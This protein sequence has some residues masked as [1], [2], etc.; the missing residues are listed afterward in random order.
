MN[1]GPRQQVPWSNP[2]HVGGPASERAAEGL[3]L[4]HAL[5]ERMRTGWAM[6]SFVIELPQPA[7]LGVLALAGFDFL[8]L[9]MEHSSLGFD[10]LEP[11]LAYGRA[12]GLPMLVRTWGE[13]TGL[14]G[15][16]L[17]MGAHGIMAP[18]VDSGTRAREVVDESRFPPRGRRGFSP[19]TR[20]DCLAEPVRQLDEATV[21]VVQ[22]EG[23]EALDDIDAIA[24][25]P[26][27]DVLFIGPY[28]LA[29]SLGVPPNSPPVFQA[30][31][32]LARRVPDHVS[33]GIYVDD[34]ASCKDWAQRGFS[35]QCVSFDSRMLSEGARDLVRRARATQA[36]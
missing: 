20:F 21:V 33:L 12:I 10:R 29:L 24:A 31:E 9:D 3:L 25:V 36:A 34:P 15:K 4:G 30:A 11:L 16:V 14:I 5:R 28:D 27:I 2:N 18:H 7:T 6:G 22:I 35:L 23:R 19:L 8:V 32:E 17:D 26:G 1:E 13:D